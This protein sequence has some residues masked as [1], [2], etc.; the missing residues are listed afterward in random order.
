MGL[1]NS[2]LLRGDYPEPASLD[3]PPVLVGT[4]GLEQAEGHEVSSL[5]QVEIGDKN[6]R[7]ISGC[8]QLFGKT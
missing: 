3:Q 1:F 6:R 2:I 8:S 7:S 4:A 5:I